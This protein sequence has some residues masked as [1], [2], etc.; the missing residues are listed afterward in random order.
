[1]F[2]FCY[3]IDFEDD[4]LDSDRDVTI[5]IEEDVKAEKQKFADDFTPADNDDNPLSSDDKTEV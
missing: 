1:M 4:S 2:V 3:K 5:G